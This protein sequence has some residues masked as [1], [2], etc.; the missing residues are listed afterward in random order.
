M[1][2][3]LKY[4]VE[5]AEYDVDPSDM[6]DKISILKQVIRENDPD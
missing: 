1:Q 2:K 4:R 5:I 6:K 3:V